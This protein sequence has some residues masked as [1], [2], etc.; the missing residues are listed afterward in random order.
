MAPKVAPKRKVRGG[1]GSHVNDPK[2][3]S[4]KAR[5]RFEYAQQKVRGF[6]QERGMDFFDD[7]V[8]GI[9]DIVK[10]L[11]WHK[12]TQTPPSAVAPIVEE[13]YANLPD[14]YN[15][16]T[17]VR[18]KE[19]KFDAETINQY[20]ELPQV[21]E[22]EYEEYLK[23]VD[24]DKISGASSSKALQKDQD[25]SLYDMVDAI[26]DYQRQQ[27]AWMTAQF[28]VLFNMERDQMEQAGCD[29]SRYKLSE[30]IYRPSEADEEDDEKASDESMEE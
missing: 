24:Y 8:E 10:K 20:Y 7:D 9:T 5:E 28:Q 12:F 25:E 15:G 2:F 27:T 19:V 23:N 30:M 3:V 29:P 16:K 13:F 18:G 26:G 22:D 11:G 21:E 4:G 14:S 17:R 1:Q 6:I